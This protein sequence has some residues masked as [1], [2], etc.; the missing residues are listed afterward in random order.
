MNIKLYT[1]YKIHFPLQDEIKRLENVLQS[2]EA[3]NV[4]G[5]VFEAT[6]NEDPETALVIVSYCLA[7]KIHCTRIAMISH[8]QL[9]MTGDSV[10]DLALSSP[11]PLIPA[12]TTS[13]SDSDAKTSE[14][15]NNKKAPKRRSQRQIDK[16]MKEEAER[17]R[18]ENQA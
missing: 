16:E 12:S 8:F 4:L 17:I 13:T 9:D 14:A 2:E 3:R 11:P 1:L 10:G 18:M 15:G 5:D 6:N 7:V